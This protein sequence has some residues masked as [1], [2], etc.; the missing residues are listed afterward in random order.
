MNSTNLPAPNAW[1]FIAQLV[2]LYNANA[3]VTGSIPVE[4][5]KYFWA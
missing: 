1:V 2:E 5:P 3:E 4:A